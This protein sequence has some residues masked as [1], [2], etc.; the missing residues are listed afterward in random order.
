VIINATDIAKGTRFEFTQLQFDQ[1]Y[2][3]LRT[4]KVGHAV[5]ASAAFPG[6]FP[7]LTVRNYERGDDYKMP[8][9]ADQVLADDNRETQSF[10]QA[11]MFQAYGDVG[12]SYIHLSDGGVADNLGLLPVINL[13]RRSSEGYGNS[14]GGALYADAEQILIVTVNAEVKAPRSWD[15]LQ[16]P[17]GLFNTLFAAGT[18]PLSKF[19]GAQISYLKL[20]IRNRMLEAE[21]SALREGR[22]EPDLAPIH[23]VEV[24]INHV[25]DEET[26]ATLNAMP[27]S[28]SLPR[29]SVDMLRATAREVLTESTAFQDFLKATREQ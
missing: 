17:V 8:A 15:M 16:S 25:K 27:T 29:E 23:F 5:A 4:Y 6:A 21:L 2:S 18:T 20:F 28:F 24:G 12:E 13:L 10:R 1:L 7:P 11:M 26:C 14:P 9:W 19:S 22:E 3:D